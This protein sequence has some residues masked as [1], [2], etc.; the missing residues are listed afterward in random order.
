MNTHIPFP[1]H[2]LS[3]LCVLAKWMAISESLA[4][5]VRYTPTKNLFCIGKYEVMKMCSYYYI[6]SSTELVLHTTVNVKTKCG[7]IG[8]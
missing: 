4:T 5:F 2:I 3:R 7:N 1:T 6:K 8:S